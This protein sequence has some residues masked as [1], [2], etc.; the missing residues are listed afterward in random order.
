[1]HL[2]CCLWG[3]LKIEFILI[4]YYFALDKYVGIEDILFCKIYNSQTISV[5]SIVILMESILLRK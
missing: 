5:K 1:M 4:N 3:G 2:T